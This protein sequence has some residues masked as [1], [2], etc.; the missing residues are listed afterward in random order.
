MMETHYARI[1]LIVIASFAAISAIGGGM[2]VMLTNGLGMPLGWLR[3]TP[4]ASYLLPGLILTVVVGGSALAA[5]ILLV[6]HHAWGNIVAL[7]AGAIMTGWIIAEV[8][9]IRQVAWLQLVY[10]IVGLAMMEL[11]SVYDLY[12]RRQLHSLLHYS[13]KQREKRSA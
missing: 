4:F 11:A 5:A 9:L 2:G 3:F 6:M 1:G 10:F 13:P 7:G 12:T 8:F